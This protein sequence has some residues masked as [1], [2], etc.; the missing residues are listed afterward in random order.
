MTI[1]EA[2]GRLVE[3][4]ESR[5]RHQRPG[6]GEHLLLAAGQRPATGASPPGEQREEFVHPTA[7]ALTHRRRPR[8]ERTGVQIFL[9]RQTG[10]DVPSFRYL[11]EPVCHGAGGV[12]TG[13]P[14]ATE[15]D[16]AFGD[17]AAV[18]AERAG[19]GAH[20]RRLA[21]AV[22]AEERDDAAA[23]DVQGHPP[24]NG[25]ASA[26]PDDESIDF[27]HV[28]LP[29]RPEATPYVT[30]RSFVKASANAV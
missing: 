27:E 15:P 12:R 19:D 9:H 25:R 7:C 17:P 14:F 5:L 11:Y 28:G 8:G 13:D 10:E 20:E 23:A 26:V 18:Q 3:K 29:C 16:G 21:G 6:D 4:Q 24:Q 22:A 30:H 2:E 1:R